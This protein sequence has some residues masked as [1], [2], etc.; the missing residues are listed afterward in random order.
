MKKVTNRQHDEVYIK[1]EQQTI[2]TLYL[3]SRWKSVDQQTNGLHAFISIEI[4]LN[5][6]ALEHCR[7]KLWFEVLFTETKRISSSGP[8]C[9][10]HS[11][12]LSCSAFQMNSAA[13]K[14]TSSLIQFEVTFVQ[15]HWYHL[16]HFTWLYTWMVCLVLSS[17]AAFP[18]TI[19]ISITAH[20]HTWHRYMVHAVDHVGQ[21][22]SF[23][24]TA[25]MKS[26][27]KLLLARKTR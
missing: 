24:T 8:V 21:T 17:S 15:Q 12:A 26:A 7:N 3:R 5:S 6:D 16:I 20:K 18:V 22:W 25:M 19:L 9:S 27:Y 1:T 11:S 10:G 13:E 2:H 23:H 14:E 4:E